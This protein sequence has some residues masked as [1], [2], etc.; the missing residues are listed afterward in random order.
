M[1]ILDCGLLISEIIMLN[2]N[3]AGSQ[4]AQGAAGSQ[5][6]AGAQGA[7]GAAGSIGS[8]GPQGAQGAQGTQGSQGPQG[9]QGSQGLAGTANVDYTYAATVGDSSVSLLLHMEGANNSTTFTDKSYSPKT[10]TVTGDAKI[11]TAASKFGSSSAY[12]DGNGD[13]ISF[14]YSSDFDFSGGTYTIEGW[15]NFSSMPAAGVCPIAKH[16][17]AVGMDWAFYVA[18]STT[19]SFYSAGVNTQR[20]ISAI[21]FGTWYHFAVVRS[22]GNVSIYWNGV[23]Q[24]AAFSISTANTGAG[25]II[26]ADRINSVLYPFHGYLDEIRLT[27][28]VAKYASDFT[29]STSAFNNADG[30]AE[31]VATNVG[32]TLYSSDGIY[33]CS[34]TSPLTWKKYASTPTTIVF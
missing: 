28:G 13:F 26:G 2:L 32:D 4:G 23:R 18:N 31:L 14:A 7:Q 24:G 5:G 15:I 21:S 9:V 11:S 25:I 22:G 33:V 1:F 3:I 29:P 30:S 34:S 10:A 20:T 19:I 16:T 17:Y 6:A 27:K 12:F 8:D